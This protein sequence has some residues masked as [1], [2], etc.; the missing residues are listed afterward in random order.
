MDSLSL[1]IVEDDISLGD[2]V[3]DILQSRGHQTIL[4]RDGQ[5]AWNWL[6]SHTP[7]CV[8]LDMHLPNV[9]GMDI[10]DKIR[11]TPRLSHIK[12][13][14]V[15][16]DALLPRLIEHKADATFTKPFS[17]SQLINIIARLTVQR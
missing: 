15:T 10:L 13:L 7:D 1:L 8:I 14:A 3:N 16:A 11:A 12:V 2:I 9:S 17:V 4:V 5:L 6:D